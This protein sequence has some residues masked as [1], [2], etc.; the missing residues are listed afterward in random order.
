MQQFRNPFHH[1]PLYSQS[2]VQVGVLGNPLWEMTRPEKAG[3]RAQAIATRARRLLTCPISKVL[4]PI[5]TKKPER[6]L[7]HC[8][9]IWRVL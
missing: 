7:L 9:V 8:P 5:A 2:S 4:K 6:W 1:R 3:H